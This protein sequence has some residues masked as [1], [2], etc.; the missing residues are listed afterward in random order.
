MARVLVV[1]DAAFMAMM[2]TNMLKELGHEV[3]GTA[4][5]GRE[6]VEEY[7]RLKPDVVTMDLTMPEV[8]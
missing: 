6:A 1:D 7:K 2:L 8:N 5:N 3:V 4:G